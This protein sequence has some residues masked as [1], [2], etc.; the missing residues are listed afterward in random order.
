[1]HSSAQIDFAGG[2]LRQVAR[3]CN[4]KTRDPDKVQYYATSES[5]GQFQ[6]DVC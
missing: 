2:L 6:S 4:V 1:M 5:P 3:L